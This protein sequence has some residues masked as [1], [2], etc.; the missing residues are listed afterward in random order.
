MNQKHYRMLLQ[1][2][3]TEIKFQK[4]KNLL[5]NHVKMF[6]IAYYGVV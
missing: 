4:I 3:I 1:K 5:K 6:D 2:K